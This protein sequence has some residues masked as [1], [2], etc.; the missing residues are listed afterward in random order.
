MLNFLLLTFSISILCV[1][2][3]MG[4]GGGGGGV[5]RYLGFKIL[6]VNI[7]LGGGPEK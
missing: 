4:G 7:F 5:I 3:I 1:Y 6:N 2:G